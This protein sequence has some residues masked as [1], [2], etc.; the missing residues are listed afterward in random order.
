MGYS[1]RFSM[2]DKQDSNFDTM[3]EKQVV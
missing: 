3:K 2:I 1:F